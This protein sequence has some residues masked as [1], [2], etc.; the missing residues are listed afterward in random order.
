VRIYR[1]RAVRRRLGQAGL[2]PTGAHHAHGLHAPYWWLRC[3]LG[4][5]NEHR[6]PVRLYHRLLVWDIVRRPAPTRLL[7]RALTPV[8][9][10]SLVM[11]ARR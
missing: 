6:W 7:D 8:I 5:D 1:A 10:K 3:A 9:G 4:V 2:T 11:Y